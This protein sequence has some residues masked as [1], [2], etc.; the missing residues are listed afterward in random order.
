MTINHNSI[1]NF[2]KIILFFSHFLDPFKKKNILRILVYHH[3]EKKYFSRFENQLKILSKDWKFIT[4][5]QFEDHVN[6]KKI[7]KGR[8]LLITFDDG[9][10]SNFFVEKKILEKFD[11]KAIFFVPSDFIKLNSHS[12]TQKFINENILDHI[13]PKNFEKLKSM[14]VK[15][16]KVLLK[17]GHTIGCHTKTHANLASIEN[18]FELKKEILHSA[19]NLENLLKVDITHFAY[20]YGNY[21]S[22]SKRSFMIAKKKYRFIYSCLRGNNFYNEKN[23]LIKRDT[24]YL[25]NSNNLLKIFLSGII[26]LKYLLKKLKIDKKLSN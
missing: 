6:K 3:I 4:P 1:K 16:L 18:F 25:E 21:E 12:K 7:L 20:T 10:K 13:R 11:I 24:V 14:T 26:D 8:N 23:T 15:D 2:E 5:S 19:K 22:I 17:K 9:F